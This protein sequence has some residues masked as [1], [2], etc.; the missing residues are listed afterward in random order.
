MEIPYQAQIIENQQIAPGAYLLSFRR[1][2]EFQPGQVVAISVAAETKPR[3]YSIASGNRDPEVRILYN[4][5]PG[6]TL[7]PELAKL[8]PDDVIYVSEPFGKFLPDGNP[9]WWIAT[10]TGIAP[11]ASMLYSGVEKVQRVIHGCRFASGFYFDKDFQ[12]RFGDRYTRCVSREH[13]EDLF[14]GRVTDYL[15]QLPSIETNASYYL[16]GSSEMVVEVRDIL[17]ERGVGFT[18]IIAEIFF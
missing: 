9:V 17:I 6:G 18:Q 5:K 1:T 7:T 3:L 11:F 4:I 16:C 13:A 2:F 10:G 14:H 8:K 12:Q 15:R